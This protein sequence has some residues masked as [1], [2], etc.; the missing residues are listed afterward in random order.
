MVDIQNGDRRYLEQSRPNGLRHLPGFTRDVK[1][2]RPITVT[3]P[4]EYLCTDSV[5]DQT[6]CDWL[7][8]K[9]FNDMKMTL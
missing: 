5:Q 2:C 1:L 4:V 7:T 8:Y 9:H 6:P 3:G